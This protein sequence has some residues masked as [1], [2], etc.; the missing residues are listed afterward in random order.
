[1]R[2]LGS[3]LAHCKV[4]IHLPLITIQVRLPNSPLRLKNKLNA[5]GNLLQTQLTVAKSVLET[6]AL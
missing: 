3:V 2:F 1:L 6:K 4:I 5:K